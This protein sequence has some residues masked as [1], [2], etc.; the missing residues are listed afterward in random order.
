MLAIA[1][2]GDAPVLLLDE[3]ANGLDV[4]GREQMRAGLRRACADGRIVVATGHEVSVFEGLPSRIAE[5]VDGRLVDVTEAHPGLRR[6]E[7][8]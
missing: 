1:L 3:F 8:R 5:L 7:E 6:A 4:V 2:A